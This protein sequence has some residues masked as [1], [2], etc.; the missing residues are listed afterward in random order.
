MTFKR[1]F[2]ALGALL[3]A[4]SCLAASVA[5]RSPFAQ[6]VWWN[7]ARS[8][9]G[10]QIFNAD[11]QVAL[12][13]YTYDDAGKPIWYIAQGD[14]GSLGTQ[15]WP[16]LKHRWANGRRADGTQVGTVRLTVRHP[17]GMD[18]AW[19]IG[20]KQGTWAI[21]PFT[22]SGVINET[23]H[24]G[25]WFDPANSGWGFSLTEQGDIMGGLL[26]TYDTA[27]APTWVAGFDRTPN[28]V[29]LHAFTGS[30]TACTY[31]PPTTRSVGRLSFDFQSE[32]RITV[33]NEMTLPMAAGVN[34]GGA[35]LVSLSRPASWRAA[36]RQLA[37]F[38]DE[39]SLKTYLDAGMMHLPPSSGG[40]DFSAAPPA[41]AYS[42]TNLVESGV[43]EADL[44]KT[45]GRFV[46][47][48]APTGS[49]S[50]PT[51]RFAE[52]GA[53]GA[54][55]TIRGSV[56]L[57]GGSTSQMASTGLYLDGDKLVSVIGT[58][59]LSVSPW[60][61]PSSWTQ[62][63][64]HVEVM[65][66]GSSGVPFTSWRAEIEGHVVAS[67]RIGQRLYVISR[68]APYV[69]GF[70][71]GAT[72]GSTVASNRQLLANTPL[73]AMLPNVR[74]N[75]GAP[76]PVVA[77]SA[78]H[79]P[80]QGSRRPMANM[81][82]VT[83]I[84]LGTPH[85][86]QA[87]AVIG[88]VESVYASST[89]L[90]VASSRHEYRSAGGALLPVQPTFTLTDVHQVRLGTD[91]MSIV[92]S[93][94]IEGFLSSDPE[95]AAFRLSEHQGRLRAV[96]SIVRAGGWI[97][98]ISNRL[99]ILEPSALAPGLLRTVSWL[100]NARRPQTLGK[101][102][103]EL[104]GTRFVGDRLYAV[105]YL[106]PLGVDPLYIV[107]LADS[108]DPRI[109]G[110]L[111][112]PGFSDYLHPLANDLLLGFGRDATST[113]ALQGLQVSLYDVRDAGKPREMQ[114]IVIGTGGSDSALLRDHHALSAL[115]KADGSLSIAFPARILEGVRQR[116]G[117]MRYELRGAGPVDARLEQGA[118][119]ITHE[120]AAGL[121]F[122]DP[123]SNGRSVLFRNGAV[124]IGNGQFWHQ[125]GAGSTTGPY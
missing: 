5:D 25:L 119:L 69:P 56:T 98:D 62:G 84:D 15:S 97:S 94:S 87:L 117:L 79:A 88:N 19:E 81:I 113:G 57:L 123:A 114:R 12:L 78:V 70:V 74:I 106:A 103:E 122:R 4:S 45:N 115:P 85:V 120:L 102:F 52:V 108:A 37:S 60:M 21:Q 33:F 111:E 14:L 34:I 91:A 99:T 8:G 72:S 109:S 17:E 64:T 35:R 73:S 101:P 95:R 41:A 83:A 20:G 48:Y 55:L 53:E 27:G 66:L 24:S 104:H 51:V 13:W 93:A 110:T 121:G 96:T 82:L 43:D 68:Y 22:I 112:V 65:S 90:F 89:D 71:F 125:D 46:Y 80:P 30:C 38:S 50:W 1:V 61:A 100:P 11:G 75:G 28:T 42:P 118:H 32:T 3:I 23:D 59:P 29:E 58:Q 44:V 40:A 47:A 6:G 63:I 92:G 116:S 18:L 54:T 26:F 2:L 7:P 31:N 76:A 124:Y 77:A 107:D 49:S 39:A 67:R 36:D 10:F 105:T 86:A 16:L 9:D